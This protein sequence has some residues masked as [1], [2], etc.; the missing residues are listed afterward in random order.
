MFAMTELDR[1]GRLLPKDIVL[2]RFEP[3]QIVIH[4]LHVE[5]PEHFGQ[6]NANFQQ[7]K[8]AFLN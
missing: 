6:N 4:E 2:I 1:Q 8:A 3:V 7:C 5:L